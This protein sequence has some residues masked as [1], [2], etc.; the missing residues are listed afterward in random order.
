MG[1]DLVVPSLLHLVRI[2][3]LSLGDKHA[4]IVVLDWFN[5]E[6]GI[7]ALHSGHWGPSEVLLSFTKGFDVDLLEL[8]YFDLALL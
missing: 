2:P 6:G 5:H 1:I 8:H 4:S 7:R 3:L